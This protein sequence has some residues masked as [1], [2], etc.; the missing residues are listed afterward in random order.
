MKT[1]KRIDLHTFHV[2]TI[3]VDLSIDLLPFTYFSSFCASG[4]QLFIL[5]FPCYAR[6][7]NIRYNLVYLKLLKKYSPS[8]SINICIEMNKVNKNARYGLVIILKVK[9]TRN[10]FCK[11]DYIWKHIFFIYLCLTNIL[12]T[13]VNVVTNYSV[14]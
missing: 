4:A 3:R 13:Y 5:H 2:H 9:W 6:S 12:R 11:F 1:R 8:M 10:V 14:S 7:Q